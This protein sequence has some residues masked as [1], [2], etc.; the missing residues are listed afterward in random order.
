VVAV[1]LQD[2][3][4]EE[5]EAAVQ[6]LTVYLLLAAVAEDH[7]TVIMILPETAL[8]VLEEEEQQAH[9][10]DPDLDLKVVEEIILDKDIQAVQV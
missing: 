8:A 4:I 7:G 3:Q 5:T 6:Y 2:I 10:K 9:L 1:A